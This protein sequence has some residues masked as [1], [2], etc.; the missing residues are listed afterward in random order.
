[1]NILCIGDV[2][3]SAGCDWLRKALPSFKKQRGV[4]LVV[5]NGE[6]SQ[7]GNGISPASA[8]HLFASGV[9]VVTG[10]NHTFRQ[11]NVFPLLEENPFLLRP[12]NYPA[13]AP[14]GG[15]TTVDLGFV[16]VAVINLMGTAFLEP[17]D[18]P[19]AAAD[20]LVERAKQDGARVVLVDFHA[21]AT[22]EKKA[23]AFYLD[24]R[25][26]ALVGTHT[27]VQTSDAQILPGGTGYLTDLGMT[28]PAL[29]VLGVKPELSVA[30]MKDKIP[31]RFV[32]ADGPCVM[33]GCL[34]EVDHAT[35]RCRSIE[36]VRIAE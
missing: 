35:G 33:E 1:M 18:C 2:V 32:N 10:G 4:D 28:G 36:T 8:E 13:S 23:L 21:E 22:A 3:G 11:R 16:T 19:F 31:V 15:Y 34:L 27:H 24:G 20:R 6:N 29:S 12:A 9:D 30:R 26:T 5:A 7:D 17:L 25:I 14:G